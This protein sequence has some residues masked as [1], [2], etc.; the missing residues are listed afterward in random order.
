[1]EAS[2]RRVAIDGAEEV[3]DGFLPWLRSL[4]FSKVDCSFTVAMDRHDR[5]VVETRWGNGVTEFCCQSKGES[6]HDKGVDRRND[7]VMKDAYCERVGGEL[8]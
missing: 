2:F 7:V 8:F 5:G 1:M 6:F 4:A 3:E